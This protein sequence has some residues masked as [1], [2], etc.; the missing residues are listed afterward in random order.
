MTGMQVRLKRKLA[1]RIDGIDLS[2]HEVGDVID[3][4]ERKARILVAEGWGV[5]ERRSRE[6]GSIVL[7][8]RRMDDPGPLAEEHT[9]ISRA[10]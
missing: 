1:Q 7:A 3:L 2:N 6:G 5:V 9:K 8:F 10:S 4:P